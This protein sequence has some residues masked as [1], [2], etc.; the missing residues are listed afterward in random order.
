MEDCFP[1]C[2]STRDK[3]LVIGLKLHSRQ[4]EKQPWSRTEDR[5]GRVGRRGILLAQRLVKWLQTALL[6][7]MLLLFRADAAQS[8]EIRRQPAV[9]FFYQALNEIARRLRTGPNQSLPERFS[10]SA[11]GDENASLLNAQTAAIEIEHRSICC[12]PLETRILAQGILR[13]RLHLC[14][15]PVHTRQI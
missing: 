10:L 6:G 2:Q 9:V 12:E 14:E 13:F 3:G 8:V 7:E 1:T 4:Q 5:A 11:T 15:S